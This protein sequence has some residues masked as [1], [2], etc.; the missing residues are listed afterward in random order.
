MP[1]KPIQQGI[2][3]WMR[4]D[5]NN[6]YVSAFEVYT[7]KKGNTAEKGLGVKVVKGLTEQLHGTYCHVFYDNF[8]PCVDLVLDL[9]KAGLYSCG[10]LK[11]NCKAFPTLL[12]LVVKKDL[13]NGGN[14]KNVPAR[15]SYRKCMAR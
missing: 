12:K 10:I 14:S 6:G 13:G 3:V 4:A 15:K 8:F 5:A 7:S 2:K 1:L 9:F 11:S